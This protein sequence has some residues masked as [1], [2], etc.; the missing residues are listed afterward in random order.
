MLTSSEE[1]LWSLLYLTGYLTGM[2][3]GELAGD[4]LQP[5]QVALRIPNAEIRNIFQKSVKAWFTEQP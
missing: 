1:N 2:R 3:K 5:G 4:C